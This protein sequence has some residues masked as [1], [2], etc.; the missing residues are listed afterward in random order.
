[1][2]EI[3]LFLWIITAAVILWETKIIRMVLWLGL[4]SLIASLVFLFLGAPDVAFAEAA[5]SGFSTIFFIVCFEKYFSLR[6]KEVEKEEEE[7][8][9]KI[10]K[11]TS[12]ILPLIFTVCLFSLFLYFS[13]ENYFNSYLKEQY[14]R[15]APFDVGGENIV[16]AIYLGYRV[17]D[18]LFEALMLV[19][20]VV[21]VIHMSQFSETS[22]KGGI[23][24]EIK[25]SSV[26]LFLMRIVAPLT[27][28]FGIYLV[29]FG[30][31]A[32]GG[33]FQG[34][35]AV[36]TF[37]ICRYLVYDIYDIPMNKVN[38]MEEIVFAAITILAV[39]II[40]QDAATLISD[41]F[42]P[43]FQ[44]IYLIAMNGL[45]GMKVACGFLILFYRYVAIE[46]N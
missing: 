16:G 18:T 31:L 45:I 6:D 17:F 38:K 23:Q 43:T 29:A 14:I 41:E 3:I 32:A 34:G 1:M 8:D 20:A 13:P 46:R 10:N 28:V 30:F 7:V 42:V 39:L 36:A 44:N 21:A 11:F 2:F 5:I 26:A 25:K 40:F 35:L 27:L 12:Y 37:F 19:V 15:R 22:I 4:S 9:K 24:S 33:G